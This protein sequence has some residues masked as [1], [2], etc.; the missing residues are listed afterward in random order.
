MS[1]GIWCEIFTTKIEYLQSSKFNN[2][3]YFLYWFIFSF[4]LILTKLQSSYKTESPDI[5]YSKSKYSNL[6]SNSGFL[7][8][9]QPLFYLQYIWIRHHS[10]VRPFIP[11][12]YGHR[13]SWMKPYSTDILDPRLVM[14]DRHPGQC[15][16]E[17][18]HTVPTSWIHAWLWLI[19]IR[20]SVNLNV[21]I[22][23]RHPGSTPDYDGSSDGLL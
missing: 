11:S 6:S 8:L 1:W 19:V 13:N 12:L 20:V 22:Q 3:V 21:T 23:Y 15:K 4:A 10:C 5:T 14:M 16:P 18:H 17:C 7:A 2:C 9:K